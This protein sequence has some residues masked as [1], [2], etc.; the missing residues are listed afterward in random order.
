MTTQTI[1]REYSSEELARFSREVLSLIKGQREAIEAAWRELG[2]INATAYKGRG[3]LTDA[4]RAIPDWQKY[5]KYN[6]E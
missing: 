6:F 5:N 1:N 4:Q 3:A 2:V